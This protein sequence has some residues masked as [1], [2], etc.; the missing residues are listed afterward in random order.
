MDA[1][2]TRIRPTSD[3]ASADVTF[4][5]GRKARIYQSGGTWRWNIMDDGPV[6]LHRQGETYGG[7][8]KA[9][10]C[11]K[12]AIST[13]PAPIEISKEELAKLAREAEGSAKVATRIFRD[14]LRLRTGRAWSATIG[15]G[16]AYSWITLGAPRG[17]LDGYSMVA[18]D[19][20]TLSAVLG[21]HVGDSH[22]VR[23][24]RGVRA[25]YVYVLAGHP[26]PDDLVVS[27][28][29]WD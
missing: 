16:T 24:C 10:L 26:V 11:A 2:K 14:L 8:E 6:M 27:A 1:T 21:E 20:V 25:F 22:S 3:G 13:A 29:S 23:P 7:A 12:V 28:P 18:D 5:C 15:R 17:R 9:L 4:P 19:V